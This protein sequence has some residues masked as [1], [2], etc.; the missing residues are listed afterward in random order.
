VSVLGG[1]HQIAVANGLY[2]DGV[3]QAQLDQGLSGQ[4]LVEALRMAEEHL[5]LGPWQENDQLNRGYQ[6]QD[7]EALVHRPRLAELVQADVEV[8]RW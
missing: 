8:M 7:V 1:D 3:L 6:G 5:V 4:S 2:Q